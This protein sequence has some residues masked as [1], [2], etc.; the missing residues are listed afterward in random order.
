[1]LL[2][3][4]AQAK[5][6]NSLH[7]ALPTQLLHALSASPHAWPPSN[8]CSVVW[9][10]T[11]PQTKTSK[12]ARVISWGNKFKPCWYQMA[13]DFVSMSGRLIQPLKIRASTRTP[14]LRNKVCKERGGVTLTRE[15][16]LLSRTSAQPPVEPS[17]R[18]TATS[19]SGGRGCN[20]STSPG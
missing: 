16:G 7:P 12:V 2:A 9:S 11:S 10:R 15:R 18:G 5:P 6:N 14:M 20:A 13:A 17:A 19:W 4:L 3:T 1:M 8:F